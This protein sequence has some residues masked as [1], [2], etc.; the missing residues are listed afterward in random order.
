[1]TGGDADN[2]HGKVRPFPS[3]SERA[4]ELLRAR[5]RNRP[6]PLPVPA[7]PPTNDV[8]GTPAFP[9]AAV[10]EK[11]VGY[12]VPPRRRR[13]LA[14]PPSARE[15]ARRDWFLAGLTL[16]FLAGALCTGLFVWFLL[17]FG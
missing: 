6:R 15:L 11:H 9:A 5:S 7:L 4:D 13:P 1:M 17:L 3:T 12:P 14:P 8:A 10:E 16:G 2:H